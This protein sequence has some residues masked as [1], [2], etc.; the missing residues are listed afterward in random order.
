MIYLR[1]R[2]MAQMVENFPSKCKSLNSNPRTAKRKKKKRSDDKPLALQVQSPK[3]NPSPLPAKKIYLDP[4]SV[5]IFN[6]VIMTN[7]MFHMLGSPWV[8]PYN[9]RNDFC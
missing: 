1:A 9:R 6:F 3:L 2:G 4:F 7:N 8:K 5:V